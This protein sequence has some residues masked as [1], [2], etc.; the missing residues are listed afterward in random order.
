MTHQDEQK[1]ENLRELLNQHWLHCRHLESERAWFLNVYGLVIAGVLTYTVYKHTT[2]SFPSSPFH[3][4]SDFLV[5]LTF[6]GFFLTLRWTYAFECH[7]EKVNSLARIIWSESGVKSM[8]NP[9][10][11]IP[12]MDIAPSFIITPSFEKK[13]IPKLLQEGVN[14]IFRTRYWFSLFYLIILLGFA[15]FSCVAHFPGLSKG[16]AIAAFVLASFL[17]LRCYPSLE[18]GKIIEKISLKK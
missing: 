15:I 1:A 9:T 14:N 18:K 7:R 5:V 2:P 8:L 17:A 13:E 11:D 4:L 6:I 12:P 10:M 16:I 3:L